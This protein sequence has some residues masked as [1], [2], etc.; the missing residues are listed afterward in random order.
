MFFL[1]RWYIQCFEAHSQKKSFET[2][3][4]DELLNLT[5]YNVCKCNV[6]TRR[7]NLDKIEAD[8]R[9]PALSAELPRKNVAE[10]PGKVR[11]DSSYP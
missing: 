6:N 5:E 10:S 7:W 4:I 2:S 11:S 1:R 3:L 9:G 8:R